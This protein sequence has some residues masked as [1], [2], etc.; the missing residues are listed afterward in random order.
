MLKR[1]LAPPRPGSLARVFINRCTSVQPA[2]RIPLE[3]N[4]L[5]LGGPLLLYGPFMEKRRSHREQCR[6]RP[7]PEGTQHQWGLGLNRT[8]SRQAGSKTQN[9]VPC[10][11]QSDP[12]FSARPTRLPAS[13]GLET[14]IP[15]PKVTIF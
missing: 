9:V 2:A 8:P 4:P 14:R 13:G 15:L 1:A 11:Q 12:G 5:V 6:L 10:P 7:K 3:G